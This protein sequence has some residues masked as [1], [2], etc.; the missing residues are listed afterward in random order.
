[1]KLSLGPERNHRSLVRV[2]FP[3]SIL[4]GN[5]T[6]TGYRIPAKRF[7]HR[8]CRVNWTIQFKMVGSLLLELGRRTLGRR[9]RV[10][11]EPCETLQYLRFAQN[12]D[13]TRKHKRFEPL[14]R[15]SGMLFAPFV[16]VFH[17][18]NVSA[19]PF[20]LIGRL[21]EL[22]HRLDS[23]QERHFVDRLAQV[24]VR[25]GLNGSFDVAKFI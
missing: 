23:L 11:R 7:G 24:V 18:A 14:R 12:C 6:S 1:M 22:Q 8:R 13:K 9:D 15:N 19:E 21:L 3:A 25:A 20:E 10:G 2:P 5:A 4:K 16:V 17:F